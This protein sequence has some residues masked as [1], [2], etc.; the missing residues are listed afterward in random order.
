MTKRFK[1]KKIRKIKD[2]IIITST[3]GTLIA[4]FI[5]IASFFLYFINR[6]LS[7]EIRELE[8]IAKSAVRHFQD[9]KMNKL[10]Q[11]YHNYYF[12]DKE[13]MSVMVKENGL[14]LD[15][16][17]DFNNR[18][19]KLDHFV[20][21]KNRL[22][23]TRLLT[24][25][26]GREYYFSRNFKFSDFSSIFYIMS[27][28]FLLVILTQFVISSLVAKNILTPVSEI[29]KRAKEIQSHNI[30]VR[31]MKIRDDEIGDLVN[32]INESFKRKEELIKSQKKFS[33]DIS[34]ELKTP[35]AIMKGYLD[36]LKWGKGNEKILNESFED[37]NEEIK[38]MENIINTLFL[39]SN[40]EKLKLNFEE[41][42][43]KS[44]FLK[45]KKDYE[46]INKNQQIEII[47]KDQESI[48]VDKDLLFEAFRGIIDNGIK[49][50]NSKK[51]ELILEIVEN[52]DNSKNKK[53]TIRDYGTGISKAEME[54]IFN[55]YY[56][57]NNLSGVG[58][59]L[60]IIK[61][62]IELNNGE[63]ELVNRKD[64]LDVN[65]YF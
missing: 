39:T 7:L 26:N 5:I 12:A 42:D 53:I 19:I 11:E 45:I 20:F 16:T 25:K 64:G 29:I 56:K 50:S 32:I 52:K 61:E 60:S 35:L 63:I 37:M 1:I 54:K 8:P 31:L 6:D 18:K 38:K 57:K 33:S 23:F 4:M 28:L 48:N 40:L 51:I 27:T 36:I 13:Y 43:I 65:L 2:K 3:L 44:F 21:E 59:G 58:L 55:R 41:I 24:D 9:F 15:L 22:V 34:H 14:K 62:I 46:I 10:K 49:Y 47:I 17:N 30:D